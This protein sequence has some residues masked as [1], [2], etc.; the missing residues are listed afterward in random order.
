MKSGKRRSFTKRT[1]ILQKYIQLF[2]LFATSSN[3]QIIN[4]RLTSRVCFFFWCSAVLCVCSVTQSWPTLWDSKDYRLLC[5]WDSSGKNTGAGCHVLLQEIFPTRDQTP[6]SCVSCIAGGF[7]TTASPGMLL[8]FIKWSPNAKIL[9]F[10]T[11]FLR[12]TF[13]GYVYHHWKIYRH[14]R[15]IRHSK[16]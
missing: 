3:N 1:T 2:S 5:P 4:N 12:S 10:Q 11:Q 16:N 9:T 7:F 6:I 13:T 15:T 8:Y 14:K